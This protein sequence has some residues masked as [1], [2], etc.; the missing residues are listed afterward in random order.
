MCVCG[1]GG[2]GRGWAGAGGLINYE[3]NFITASYDDS[4]LLWYSKRIF[5]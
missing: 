1:G 2:E 3:R 4:S 5:V